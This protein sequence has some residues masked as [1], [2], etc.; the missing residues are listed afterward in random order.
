[1]RIDFANIS[2]NGR[3]NR[4]NRRRL[5]L[6]A[7]L[8]LCYIATIFAAN[9]AL[10]RWGVIDVGFGLQ[11]TAGVY[12]AGLS[13]TLRDGVQ[14]LGNRWWVFSA[15]LIG[16]TCSFLVEDLQKIALASGAA[17]LV[18]ETLDM[19]IYTPLR[20]RGW[21]RAVTLSGIAGAFADTAIFL[22]LAFGSL[23]NIEGQVLAK[24]MVTL[25]AVGVIATVRPKK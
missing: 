1:M 24:I 17:F 4:M 12:F 10:N 8:T 19:A 14:E 7:A 13:L 23:D 22:W 15:I 16:A 3:S 21:A 20:K 2:K 18:S 11:A 9:W 25:V 5:A 6:L